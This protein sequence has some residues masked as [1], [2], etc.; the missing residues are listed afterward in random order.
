MKG[1]ILLIENSDVLKVEMPSNLSK[2][3]V[4][5]I[6]S[7]IKK[8]YFSNNNVNT[9]TINFWKEDEVI[10]VLNTS[11]AVVLIN[12][13]V[14]TIGLPSNNPNWITRFLE[15]FSKKNKLVIQLIE[16]IKNNQ[17]TTFYRF[18]KIIFQLF[19]KIF[20]KFCYIFKKNNLLFAG[21][22]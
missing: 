7:E 20:A 6:F 13:L 16:E 5:K 11:K 12:D 8:C 2:V 1:I 3:E 21:N 4:E 9:P 15:E 17:T 19:L 14:Q 22:R 18:F 10:S